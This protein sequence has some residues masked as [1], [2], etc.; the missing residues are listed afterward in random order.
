M[1]KSTSG[2]GAQLIRQLPRTFDALNNG[3]ELGWHTGALVSVRRANGATEN[4]A[5]GRTLDGLPMNN[6]Q[7]PPW[8]CTAKPLLVL[9]L[10]K[11][12][13]TGEL[14]WD[15]SVARHV[16][17]FARAGKEHVTI[18]HVLTHSIGFRADP[19]ELLG[20]DWEIAIRTI[21]RTS[22]EPGWIPGREH[23]YLPFTSWYLMGEVLMRSTGQPLS[24]LLREHVLDPLGLT[25]TYV[26]M[27]P[28]EYERNRPHLTGVGTHQVRGSA[29]RHQ[30]RL[31]VEGPDTCCGI[32]PTSV[33]GT[34]ADLARLY[35][36]IGLSTKPPIGISGSVWQ[37]VVRRPDTPVYDHRHRVPA[38]FGMGLVFEGR[39]YGEGARV[40]GP[41]CSSD[42]LGHRGLGSLV[43]YADR[44]AGLAVAAFFDVTNQAL[45]NRS[46]IDLVSS[47]A[48]EDLGLL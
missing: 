7:L 4:L 44:S 3:V 28:D 33:R 46:R 41:D 8:F 31:P 32:G 42:T 18:Q 47:C 25:E 11:L 2:S 15:D 21:A 24:P 30:F 20:L 22:L 5:V 43:A 37:E 34:I 14:H 16:P 12:I 10:A 6:R 1:V 39:Q 48:Y 17:R 27:R 45:L 23:S 38:V 40:F 35:A 13:S 29:D 36:L 9:M 19:V 26:G